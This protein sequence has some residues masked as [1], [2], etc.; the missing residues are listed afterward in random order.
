MADETN[1]ADT[2]AA[3][4]AAT[5]PLVPSPPEGADVHEVEQPIGTEFSLT[6]HES[7]AAKFGAKI[8]EVFYHLETDVENGVH[9]LQG[10]LKPTT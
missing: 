7:I 2:A 3:T 4:P 1:E 6:V 9:R 5:P 8:E 10:W